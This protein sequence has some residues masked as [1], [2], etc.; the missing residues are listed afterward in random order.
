MD[1]SDFTDIH[2]H[3]SFSMLDGT[4]NP[5]KI[6]DY[7]AKLG[8]KYLSITDHGTIDGWVEHTQACKKFG[9]Q[10]LYGIELYMVEDWEDRKTG[11]PR[12]LH[13]TAIAKTE[14]GQKKLIQAC[15]YAY[16]E[17][18]GKWGI[19]KRPFLPMD[20]PLKNGWAGNIIIATGC[21]SSPFWNAEKG[22]D[23]LGDYYD[24]FK[25]DLY[26]ETMPIYDWDKQKSINANALQA[27]ETFGIKPIATCDVH[28]LCKEDGDFHNVVIG[29]QQGSA[30]T[31]NN[32]KWKFE[33]HCS[34]IHTIE[35]IY[36]AYKKLSLDEETIRSLIINTKEIAEK[37]VHELKST[38]V[39]LPNVLGTKND[40]EELA[41]FEELIV[42][43]F[44]T[45][46]LPNTDEYFSRL[47]KEIKVIRERKFVR[48]FLMV[49][50][51]IKW[52]KSNGVFIGPARGSVGGSLVAHCLGITNLD[53]I[54]YGLFF[55]RFLAPGR[56]D[57]PDI[58][59]D[60]DSR[61]RHLVE[62]YLRQK[63]GEDRV[64]HVS[65][66]GRLMGRAAIRDVSRYYE[67]PLIEADKMSKSIIHKYDGEEGAEEL[68]KLTLEADIPG[69]KEFAE[70]YPKVV[71]YAQQLEGLAKSYGVHA[72]G[73]V[74]S[75]EPLVNSSRCY[76]ADRNGQSTVNWSG[77]DLE[78]MGFIKLD[79]LGLSTLSAIA[80]CLD[81][82]KR[83]HNVSL[84][85]T[86]IPMDDK[87]TFDMIYKGETATLFHLSTPGYTKY[88][89]ELK[90]DNFRHMAAILALWKPGPIAAGMTEGYKNCKLGLQEPLYF[91]PEYKKITE[92][93]Y[94]YVIYQEQIM[95]L[96]TELAG[97]TWTAAD[98]VRKDIS[99]KLGLDKIAAIEE[100]FVQ[101]CLKKGT[102]DEDT[103]R[104]LWKQ[105]V[106]FGVY[107]FN[108]S[109]SIGYGML[110]Y[111]TAYLKAHYPVEWLCA[112]LNYGSVD[113]EDKKTGEKNIDM[114]LREAKRLGITIKTPDINKSEVIWSVD[115]NALRV[116]LKDVVFVGDIAQSEIAKMKAAGRVK[117]LKDFLER[118]QPDS[119]L[120]KRVVKSLVYCG[121]FDE[122]PDEYLPKAVNE[123]DIFWEKLTKKTKKAKQE[124]EDYIK[125]PKM[126]PVGPEFIAEQREA[127]LKF[128]SISIDD[129]TTLAKI[130]EITGLTL[131]KNIDDEF[132]LVSPSGQHFSR[133][134]AERCD[135]PNTGASLVH[136]PDAN[137]VKMKEDNRACNKCDLRKSCNS[138]VP[139]AVGQTDIM[140]V[141][142]APGWTEDKFNQAISGKGYEKLWDIL[143]EYDIDKK[144]VC[145][146]HV[147]SCRPPEGKKPTFEQIQDC[148]WLGRYLK[149]LRPKFVL[150]LGNGPFGFFTGR[151][152]GIMAANGSTE[153]NNKYNCWTTFGITP[154]SLFYHPE[155]ESLLR[156][157]CAE[158]SRCIMQFV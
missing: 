106:F 130:A 113:K 157:A 83:N 44:D 128:N 64:G 12:N 147:V 6:A 62:H 85:M 103:A 4:A 24:A 13:L 33:T 34:H 38:P 2:V 37:T 48:Y 87:K 22:I 127:L 7:T 78:Y 46:Q 52:A 57:Y 89:K 91:S 21:A 152:K 82:V 137:F 120:D 20:Y 18:I 77:P 72:S 3:S 133:L 15:G 65:T 81:L 145:K 141:G 31:V 69:A 51:V 53:P 67:V 125:D 55:E 28:Y 123:F 107:V 74:I 76:L 88:C 144:A 50:D 41:R 70:K 90:P 86:A 96:L 79:L 115:K 116:G 136:I 8:R 122:C 129:G 93:T 140:V 98:K 36:D 142:E 114:A 9:I 121:A 117:N 146:V 139:M 10:P 39:Q 54:K 40:E 95:L 19:M 80:E 105:L 35:Q 17:G 75:Q 56:S 42:S 110:A 126:I 104:N 45:L 156:N 49:Q 30:T 5:E 118:R 11:R 154:G 134:Q 27:V 29:L 111:W 25:S 92:E 124:L 135:L 158:F 73:Y 148:E 132:S 94:G 1:N 60:I 84:D 26:A 63:Y 138:P 23:L 119:S 97:F 143:S 47:D 102:L 131:E 150:S 32:Q 16:S 151:E 155:Q 153:W 66:F 43:G 149:A 112:Y 58:D 108:K 99:K 71:K 14:E 68:I 61:N 100:P 101:G 109:H 59:I